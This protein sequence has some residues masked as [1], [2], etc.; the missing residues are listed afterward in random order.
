MYIFGSLRK[1]INFIVIILYKMYLSYLKIEN[2]KLS[3]YLLFSFLYFI[4]NKNSKI[5][6]TQL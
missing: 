6:I 5:N 3:I 2:K 4:Q 1:I